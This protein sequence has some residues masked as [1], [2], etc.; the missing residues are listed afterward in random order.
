MNTPDINQLNKT[1]SIQTTTCTLKFKTGPGNIPQVEIQNKQA[2]AII[3]LQGAHLL[4]WVPKDEEDVIWL[5]EDAS[6]NPG[7]SVR[8]GI[9][10]C[11]PWFGAHESNSTYPAHG[12]ARTVNWQ[13]CNT[14]E[15][16][17]GETQ[18]TFKLETEQLPENLQIMWPQKTTVEYVLT[19][20]KN[21]TLE[22]ITHNNSNQA[23]TIGQALHTY[24]N[25]QNVTDVNVV[26]LEG[27]AYLDKPDNFKQKKQT[28]PITIDKE[29]DRVYI[30]TTDDVIID[31]KKRKI[32]I[33][34]QGSESTVVWNP[35]KAV[36]ENMGDLG[37]EGYLKMLCVESANAADDIR[38]IDSGE[39]HQLSVSY[40][41]D[42]S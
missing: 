6:F 17:T 14:Q 11:W 18:I 8:G 19:I 9:P 16:A 35:W 41:V 10:V 22:L 3:S 39:S 28:G 4:S 37:K 27:K 5:S 12:F 7:K 20:G 34:K 2:T 15:Q 29:V 30:N 32:I 40:K 38:K 42:K 25:V 36:A 31:N 24:F 26:G 13:V 1:Y 23:I 33:S 21:L